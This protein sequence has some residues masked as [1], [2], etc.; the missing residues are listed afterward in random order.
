MFLSAGFKGEEVRE[1]FKAVTAKWRFG[2]QFR[3][4]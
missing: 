4:G 3:H 2:S 1:P